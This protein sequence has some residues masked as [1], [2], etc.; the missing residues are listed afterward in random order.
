MGFLA[1]VEIKSM[2]AIHKRW[3]GGNGNILLYD[4]YTIY[5]V[6]YYHLKIDYSIQMD[7]VSTIAAPQKNQIEV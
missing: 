4:F 5:E 3:E 7:M 6:V 2:T 1:H